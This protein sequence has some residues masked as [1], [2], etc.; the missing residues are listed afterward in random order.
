MS[1]KVI[2]QPYTSPAMESRRGAWERKANKSI[3][4]TEN[5]DPY[6]V[7]GIVEG[8]WEAA[9][10]HGD[11][12]ATVGGPSVAKGASQSFVPSPKQT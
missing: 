2:P 6:S 1:K 12:T 9:T 5:S 11:G 10:T 7:G 8:L 3:S 4:R